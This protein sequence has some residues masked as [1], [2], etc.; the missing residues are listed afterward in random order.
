M[1]FYF[2]GNAVGTRAD[3]FVKCRLVSYAGLETILTRRFIAAGVELFLDSGAFT[4]HRQGITIDIEGYARHYHESGSMYRHVANLDC[5]PGPHMP[6]A[7][8]AETS[9][10]NL[11]RLEALGCTVM[12]AFHMYEPVRYLARYVEQYSYIA[13]GGLVK[14]RDDV[15]RNWLDAC[16]QNFLTDEDGRPRVKV[17]GFGISSAWAASRYPWASLDSMS[18]LIDSAKPLNCR[19]FVNGKPRLFRIREA[20]LPEEVEARL[21]VTTQE[22]RED[23]ETRLYV[24]AAYYR[25]LE[26]Q[27][28]DRFLPS[29]CKDGNTLQR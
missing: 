21:G 24:N 13:L 16:W 5:I 20:R 26:N 19:A 6:P 23:Y 4:A 25:E 17:H 9:Y 8:A 14:Q 3:E 22:C 27:V 12:P 2:V 18:W 7:L 15:L 1:K 28:P 10:R 29:V 11:R